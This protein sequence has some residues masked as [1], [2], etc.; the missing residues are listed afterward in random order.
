MNIVGMIMLCVV[1]ACVCGLLKRYN[2]EYAVILAFAIGAI[3][4][5]RI[6]CLWEENAQQLTDLLSAVQGADE[7][8]PVLWKAALICIITRFAADN[9]ADSGQKALASQVELAGKTA[10][11]LMALPLFSGLAEIILS[12]AGG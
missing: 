10:V 7:Y 2:S 4:L 12:L 6:I 11:M 3:L 1:C 9:C 5:L 8:F